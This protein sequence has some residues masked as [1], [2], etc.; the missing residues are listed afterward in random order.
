[1][2]IAAGGE[3][4]QRPAD[5]RVPIRFVERDCLS[6]DVREDDELELSRSDTRLR[7]SRA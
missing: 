2:K 1:V 7:S 5:G 3:D 4:E 6:R